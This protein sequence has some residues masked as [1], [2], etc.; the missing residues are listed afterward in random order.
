VDVDTTDGKRYLVYSPIGRDRSGKNG[1]VHLGLGKDLT[2]GQWHTVVRDLQVDLQ[3]FQP[4]ATI[5]R[6]NSLSIRGGGRVD[7]VSLH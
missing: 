6:V 4:S 1:Q 7:N 2:D 5:T 3:R